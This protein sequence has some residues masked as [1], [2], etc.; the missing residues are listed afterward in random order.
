MLKNEFVLVAVGRV[1][2]ILIAIATLRVMTMLLSPEA[3]GEWALLMAYQSFAVL[4]LIN[5]VDQ[6]IFR[7]AHQWWDSGILLAYLNKYNLYIVASSMIILGFMVFFWNRGD[8]SNILEGLIVGFSVYLTTWN[9]GLTYLLNMLG[10]R[11]E[12][13]IWTVVASVLG[14]SLAAIFT[15]QYPSAI[16]WILGIALG[17]MVGAV[18]TWQILKRK[19][20][21]KQNIISAEVKFSSFLSRNTIYKFCLPL[22][23]AT[24]FMWL[25]N[26][27]YRFGVEKIWS[28]SELGIFIF[29]LGLATQL[30]S[31]AESL[32]T[33][34]LYPYYAR[35]IANA[36]SDMDIRRALSELINVLG[37]VYAIWAGFSIISAS[38]L[39]F[40]LADESYHSAVNFVVFGAIIEFMR[41]MTNLWSLTARAIRRTVSLILPYGVGSLA[42]ILG[43]LLSEHFSYSLVEFAV[44]LIYA[45]I[46]TCFFMILLMQRILWVSIDLPRFIASMSFLVT[47]LVFGIYAPIVTVGLGLN[48]IHL[49]L[50]GVVV[51]S[52]IVLILWKNPAL[53]RLV[54]TPLKESQL[55]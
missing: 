30:A 9:I 15:S 6:H 4:F 44:L 50:A 14:L 35:K 40:F 36:K 48:F 11:K 54:S 27:G 37:P 25:Q 5:P 33:H 2:S 53:E 3:Y 1:I 10:Y 23:F 7:H 13:V 20:V 49:V 34:F 16:A 32:A 42:T 12:S 55:R 8:N 19:G 39:L 52:A 21:E 41:C 43:L 46:V 28:I 31:I 47:C 29:G 51:V 17:S 26:I 18:R 45:S 24:G 38:A 22:A